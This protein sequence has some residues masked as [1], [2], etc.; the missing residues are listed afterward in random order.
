MI[1]LK[2]ILTFPNL[3]AVSLLSIICMIVNKYSKVYYPCPPH[4]A[5]V[6][7]L[8]A[9]LIIAMLWLVVLLLMHYVFGYTF[10]DI[11]PNNPIYDE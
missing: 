1:L 11:F 3:L 2:F 9:L 8:L 7:K 5:F 6:Q 10:R 4:N